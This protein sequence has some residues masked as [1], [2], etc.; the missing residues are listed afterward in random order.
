MCLYGELDVKIILSA[1][2]TIG[3]DEFKTVISKAINENQSHFEPLLVR[4]IDAEDSR[5]TVLDGSLDAQPEGVELNESMTEGF[6]SCTF[7]SD[8][9]AGCRDLNSTDEHEVVIEFT[10]NSREL[11]VKQDLPPPWRPDY[12]D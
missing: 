12:N 9:Y 2:S 10:I 4:L 3:I 6:I 7:M 11:I 8:F 5:T 1:D